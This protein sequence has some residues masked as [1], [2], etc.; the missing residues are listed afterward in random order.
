MA[1]TLAFHLVSPE[2]LVLSQEVEM[3]IIPGED[4]DMGILPQHAAIISVLRPGLIQIQ[5]EGEITQ[6]IFIS[7]GFA[8][9][10][11]RGCTVLSEECVFLKDIDPTHLESYI[12][13]LQDELTIARDLEERT[14]IENSLKIAN[15]KLHLYQKLLR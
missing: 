9:I 15:I 2:N 7:G 1:S 5:E 8:N 6:R 13:N 4:G 10:N 11:E 14:D 12:K 3:V